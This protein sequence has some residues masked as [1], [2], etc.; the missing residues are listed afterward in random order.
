MF[1]IKKGVYG[2]NPI[3]EG[4]LAS[5]GSLSATRAVAVGGVVGRL[6]FRIVAGEGG[7]TLK[8]GKKISYTVD[9]CDTIDGTYTSS[10]RSGDGHTAAADTTYA[11]GEVIDTVEYPRDDKV[12]AKFNLSTD[13]TEAGKVKVVLDY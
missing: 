9:E 2:E 7:F 10:V 11:E 8:S 3:D 5:G 12:F 1:D 4:T 6:C 13:N